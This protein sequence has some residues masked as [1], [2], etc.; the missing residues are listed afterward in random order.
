MRSCESCVTNCKGGKKVA[1]Q[2]SL[3]WLVF[4]DCEHVVFWC[5]YLWPSTTP[6]VKDNFQQMWPTT[7]SLELC[8]RSLQ[9]WSWD[10][11]FLVCSWNSKLS[12]GDLHALQI[13][14]VSKH[15]CTGN[16]SKCWKDLRLRM[17]ISI[18]VLIW[19]PPMKTAPTNL[20]DSETKDLTRLI[21]STS[22]GSD[23]KHR[24]PVPA[25]KDFERWDQSCKQLRPP[26]H[27][28]QRWWPGK[29]TTDFGFPNR[30]HICSHSYGTPE[31][32]KEVWLTEIGDTNGTWDWLLDSMIRGMTRYDNNWY[33]L[34]CCCCC[35]DIIHQLIHHCIWNRA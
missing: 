31:Q 26:C 2:A 12:K 3:S 24:L 5:F 7:S 13:G 17:P 35:C 1:I 14:N 19:F 20:V 22:T 29:V 34:T 18:Y 21:E 33:N 16:T 28:G 30:C 6:C 9:Q 11:Q 10:L 15:L 4:L 23:P 32:H 27:S 8:P 25:P